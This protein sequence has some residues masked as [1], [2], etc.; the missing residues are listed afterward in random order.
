MCMY[1]CVYIYFY[2]SILAAACIHKLPHKSLTV[3]PLQV[4]AHVLGVRLASTLLMK[5]CFISLYTRLL[6][7]ASTA[8][9]GLVIDLVHIHV[10]MYLCVCVCGCVCVYVVCVAELG[11][12]VGVLL[13][14]SSVWPHE[15]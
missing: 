5:V 13:G 2:S 3:L 10:S 1:V 4:L 9:A 14:S 7:P 8:F 11:I 6:L 15:N 12:S